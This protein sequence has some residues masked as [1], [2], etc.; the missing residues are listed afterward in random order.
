MVKDVTGK[1]RFHNN[2]DEFLP[3][4]QC[5]CGQKFPDWEFTISIYTDNPTEC[6]KCGAKLFFKNNI[7]VF[8]IIEEKK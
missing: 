2:D 6:R 8:E 4:V 5:I 3:I 7:Q 1:V